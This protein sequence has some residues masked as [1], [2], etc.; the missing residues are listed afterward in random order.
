[1]QLVAAYAS[2]AVVL[3]EGAI[4]FDGPVRQLFR[5]PDVL[6]RARL[7]MPPVTRLAHRLEADGMAPDVLTCREFVAAWVRRFPHQPRRKLSGPEPAC[8]D[9]VVDGR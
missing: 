5:Q 7:R 6:A 1:M 9:E 4:I 2:R 8:D 3:S